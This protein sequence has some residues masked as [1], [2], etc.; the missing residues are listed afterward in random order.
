MMKGQQTIMATSMSSELLSQAQKWP[1]DGP[2]NGYIEPF[3][4]LHKTNAFHKLELYTLTLHFDEQMEEQ[5]GYIKEGTR[6][7][8]PSVPTIQTIHRP[9]TTGHG[10]E[11]I[12]SVS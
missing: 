6:G 5:T 3:S 1:I 4:Q 8:K 9:H 2:F 10:A 7:R 11:S 12:C